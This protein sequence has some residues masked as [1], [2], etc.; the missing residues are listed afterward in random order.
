M[1]EGPEIR[2]AADKVARRLVGGALTSI[3]LPYPPIS[4]FDGVLGDASVESVT[5]RGKALLMR[6]D[7]GL[8]LYSHSQLYGRWTVNRVTTKVRWNRSLRAEFI[9]KGYAVRLWSATDVEVVP[10]RDEEAH[11]YIAKLGPDVLGKTTTP[12]VIK[13]RL[14]SPRFHGRSAASLMLDQ[15][16]V[17]GL[18]N[19]LRSEILHQA[20][21]HPKTRPKDLDSETITKWGS[22]T[23]SISIRSYESNGLTVSDELAG[24]RK[25]M[26]ERRRSYRHSAFCR[27]GK[28]C[29][30]C[31]A[32]IIRIRV[33]GRRLDMCPECQVES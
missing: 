24:K 22:L 3:K 30:V 32:T 28:D 26:G 17:A 10:T 25:E 5:S 18:G 11:P 21:V 9:S 31:G 8:T 6:F 12:D 33:S 23:K 16:F 27:N 2:R 7:N 13:S 1:P 19:Y 29:H 15:S 4:E 14:E 20:G